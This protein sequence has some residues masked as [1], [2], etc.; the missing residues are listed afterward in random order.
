M[1]SGIEYVKDRDLMGLGW[2]LQDYLDKFEG[3]GKLKNILFYTEVGYDSAA[4]IVQ[5]STGDF[6]VEWGDEGDMGVK[7]YG[8][9]SA[10]LD[11][12][13]LF[14]VG[15][16]DGEDKIMTHEPFVDVRA[17]E[18]MQKKQLDVYNPFKYWNKN[19]RRLN[20]MTVMRLK[21]FKIG[22][23]RPTKDASIF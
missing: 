23:V 19:A 12:K 4:L 5:T 18:F 3:L 10:Q 8:P 2:K 17:I 7:Q 21:G 9:D 14:R 1:P 11:E 20:I 16:L 6:L 13:R 15:M 22:P